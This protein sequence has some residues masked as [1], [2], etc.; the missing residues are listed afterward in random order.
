MDAFEFARIAAELNAAK[1]PE[2]TAEEVVEHGRETL[3]ADHAGITLITP[4]KRLR[5]VGTTDPVVLE[6]DKLQY[7]LNEGPCNDS[8]WSGETLASVRIDRDERWPVWGPRAAELGL[9]SAL[10]GQLTDTTGERIGCLNLYWTTERTFSADDHSYVQIFTTHAAIALASSMRHAQLD[11]ALD[12]RKV[13]GQA[14]GILMERHSLRPDQA[15]EVLRR[16]SQNT[17]TKLRDVAQFLVTHRALPDTD[18]SRNRA[19]LDEAV[20]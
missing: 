13:I 3:G 9:R 14:Q 7:A 4:R 1:G 11:T 10:A 2:E 5:T 6:A 20:N 8:A 17:N 18:P 19:N 15:F 16:Y 12:A